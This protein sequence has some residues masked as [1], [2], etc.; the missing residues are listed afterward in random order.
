[1][2]NLYKKTFTP[3]VYAVQYTDPK[4]N[5]GLFIEGAYTLEEIQSILEKDEGGKIK[6]NSH[7]S[8]DLEKLLQKF[9]EEKVLLEKL[10][11]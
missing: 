4:G 7:V 1:M 10:K 6:I 8:M 5:S 9:S 2:F 3:N 11:K